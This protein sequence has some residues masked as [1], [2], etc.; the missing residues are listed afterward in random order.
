M[1]DVC[2]AI[3][4]PDRSEQSGGR[5]TGGM[6]GARQGI[7]FLCVCRGAVALHGRSS[8]FVVAAGRRF[9]VGG[10]G[11]AEGRELPRAGLRR[12]RVFF[13]AWLVLIIYLK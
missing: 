13:L 4:P 1:S 11:G 3:A 6:A 10:G 7:T 5:T 2:D 12:R 9:V 8:S